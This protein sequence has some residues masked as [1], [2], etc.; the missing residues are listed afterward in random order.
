M[1]AAATAALMGGTVALAGPA[2]ATEHNS[3]A[4]R[5][6]AVAN[7]AA[8]TTSSI[9]EHAQLLDGH[10]AVYKHFSDKSWCLIAGEVGYRQGKW[11][12]WYCDGGAFGSDL[13]I[14]V[15]N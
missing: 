12:A 6:A 5:S 15:V 1:C 7:T 14:W 8:R 3:P 13:N 9:T 4:I 11:G 10:W 2:G